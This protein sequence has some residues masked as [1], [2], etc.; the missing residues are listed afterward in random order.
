MEANSRQD[1]SDGTHDISYSI[2]YTLDTKCTPFNHRLD[3]LC[4]RLD[5]FD[6]RYHI[7]YY[8]HDIVDN[9]RNKSHRRKI[10][11]TGDKIHQKP[12]YGI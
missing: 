6:N 7:L 4:S 5:K 1:I 2:L 12:I 3:K 11:H 9:R 8:R 10:I